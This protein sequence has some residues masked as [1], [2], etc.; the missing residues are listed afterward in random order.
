M[1]I[2]D[3][4]STIACS[5]PGTPDFLKTEI[6]YSGHAEGAAQAKAILSVP[7]ELF[8]DNE[9]WATEIITRLGTHDATHVDAPWHYNAKI[10]GAK[11]MT[12]DQL[13]LE[14]FFSDGVKLDMRHKGESDPVT[15][16]D[17][18]KELDRISYQLKSMDIVLIN[19]GRDAFYHQPDY[20]FKGCG[21]T[22]DATRWMYD[23][24]IRV[25]GID[26]WGWDIPLDAQAREAMAKNK[27]G[28]FWSAHQVDLP[29]S[30]MERLVNLNALPSHGFKVSCFP[31]KIEGGSAGPARVVAI[32]PD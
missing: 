32:L 4:S 27:S 25:M 16:T 29:Y 28:S 26:A 7:A 12:I 2:L 14:W 19:S 22:A 31:L 3:L 1:K 17:I 21:V 10:Q 6:V 18:K 11:A 15:I 24:G 8:R 13:P 5:S 20:I 9:G 23:Q 30:H